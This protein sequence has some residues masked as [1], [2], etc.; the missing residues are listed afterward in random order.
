MASCGFMPAFVSL[1]K[2]AVGSG[3][4]DQA[5]WIRS[6]IFFEFYDLLLAPVAAVI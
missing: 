5:F 1:P 3:T 2:D 4:V 6:A